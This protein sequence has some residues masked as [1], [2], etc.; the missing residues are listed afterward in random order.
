MVQYSRVAFFSLTRSPPKK[1]SPYVTGAELRLKRHEKCKVPGS[2][3]RCLFPGYRRIHRTVWQEFE[4]FAWTFRRCSSGGRVVSLRKD[5]R[6]REPRRTR[7]V[8]L[9]I[10]TDVLVVTGNAP[11]KSSTRRRTDRYSGYRTKFAS[12]AW[13]PSHPGLSNASSTMDSPFHQGTFS[14]WYQRTKRGHQGR[15]Q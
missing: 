7:T 11:H 9:E 15:K 2:I 10:G 3:V 5:I 4:I 13:K 6:T 12:V 1:T 14:L 8:P